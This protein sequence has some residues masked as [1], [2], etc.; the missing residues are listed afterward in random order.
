MATGTK[1]RA[2]PRRQTRDDRRGADAGLALIRSLLKTAQVQGDS[3]T[4]PRHV[5]AEILSAALQG[6]IDEA[7]YL[8]RYPDV[9]E[10]IARGDIDQARS[11]YLVSGMYEGRLPHAVKLD[12]S[13]YLKRHRDVAEAIEAGAYANA[14]EHFET[15]G[16]AEGREYRLASGKSK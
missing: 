8:K 3:V 1:A 9:A 14:L 10:A 4:L 11:H 6:E 13:D 12:Q 5:M 16:F 7:W 15:C 2:K